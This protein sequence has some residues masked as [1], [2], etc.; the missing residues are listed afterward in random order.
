MP[1]SGG[2]FC[3]SKGRH[4]LP[5]DPC[6]SS[7]EAV[8]RSD[9]CRSYCVGAIHPQTDREEQV[10][11]QPLHREPV[12][13]TPE[14]ELWVVDAAWNEKYDVRDKAIKYAWLDKRGHWARGG[15]MPLR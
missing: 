14:D 1:R 12:R 10:S 8:V 11:R 7:L 13:E 4:Y 3:C 15:E 6:G 9:R 2:V 5:F